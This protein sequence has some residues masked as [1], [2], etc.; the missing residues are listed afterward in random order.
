[1]GGST[2]R[3]CEY[4]RALT[5]SFEMVQ[6]ASLT[7]GVLGLWA[8]RAVFG[9]GSGER[10]AILASVG[11]GRICTRGAMCQPDSDPGWK[12]RVCEQCGM[13][14]ASVRGGGKV[15]ETGWSGHGRRDDPSSIVGARMRSRD[16]R[17]TTRLLPKE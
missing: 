1:M 16:V 12:D 5:V 10:D 8:G 17:T 14:V 7:D 9:G 6:P 13:T 15:D 3:S 11:F 4:P 2:T